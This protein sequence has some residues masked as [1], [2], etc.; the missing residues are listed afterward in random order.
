VVVERGTPRSRINLSAQ[1]DWQKL[2]FFLRGTRFGSVEDIGFSPPLTTQVDSAQWVVDADVSYDLTE[3]LRL[4]AGGQNLLN[5]YPVK[6]NPYNNPSGIF[7][8][9]TSAYAPSPYGVNGGYYY[10][11][12]LF[13]F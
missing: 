13:R 2:K 10:V 11:R 7:T 12:A 6:S 4:T 3:S 1:Y 8:Y 9:L 5:R